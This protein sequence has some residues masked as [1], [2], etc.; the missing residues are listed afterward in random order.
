MAT[1]EYLPSS[2]P[3]LKS[4]F[5]QVSQDDQQPVVFEVEPAPSKAASGAAGQAGAH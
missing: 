2:Y 3:E 5:Q 4:Y 1:A